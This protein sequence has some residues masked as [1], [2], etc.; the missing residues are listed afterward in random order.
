MSKTQLQANNARL[1]ALIET[2]SGKAAGG[3][4]GGGVETCSVQLVCNTSNIFGYTY[5]TYKDG[6]VVPV[7]AYES[8]TA[9]KINT[10]LQDV[11]CG[12]FIH[13]QTSIHYDFLD[14]TVS[15]T[16]T[17]EKIFT[18]SRVIPFVIVR[19]PN[20]ANSTSTITIINND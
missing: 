16:A 14:I 3:G 7:S 18:S 8:S 1:G 19:V 10:T 13:I 17:A 11:V 15:G 4:S 6:Q 2:L 12:S 5:L 20:A 9:S